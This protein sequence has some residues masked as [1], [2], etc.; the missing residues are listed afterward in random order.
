[1]LW[2]GIGGSVF[3]TALELSKKL[4]APKPQFVEVVAE[5]EPKKKK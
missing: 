1:V 3:F 5:E 2:I 4:Y